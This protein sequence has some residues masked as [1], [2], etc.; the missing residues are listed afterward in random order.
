MSTSWKHKR[1]L[2]TGGAGFIGS[3]LTE[4]LVE[5]GADVTVLDDL[6]S[7]RRENLQHL[8]DRIR[9]IE[10][11]IRQRSEVQAAIRGKEMVF[12]LAANANVPRSVKEPDLDFETNVVG[13]FNVLRAC[14]E[15]G[16]RAVVASSAA[17]YGPPR[18][19]PMDEKHPLQ[20]ISPYGAAKVSMEHLGFAYSAVHGLK[21][22][23][24]RI[25][26]TYGERQTQYVMVDL[27]RKLSENP[28]RLEVLGTGRQSRSYCHVSDACRLFMRVAES[29]HTVGRA[30]NLTSDHMLSIR[31]LAGQLLNL[32]DLRRRT[33]IHFT[34]ESW[35]GDIENLSG[36]STWARQFLSFECQ[37]GLDEGLNRLIDWLERERGWHLRH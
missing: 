29:D 16:A 32:L 12:H 26:N 10:A 37:V 22:T 2:V 3:H 34:G 23:P 5:A 33:R 28:D 35:P 13:S 25:F 8:K 4:A 18:Y 20:P 9:F 36:D 21:F 6:S 15:F 11:D 14:V 19:A 24:I 7:G 17:V 31:D 30:V 27:L 1:V